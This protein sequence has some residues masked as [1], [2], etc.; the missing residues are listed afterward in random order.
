MTYDLK[1]VL[2]C[3]GRS[4]HDL[5]VLCG[6]SWPLSGPFL[7][8]LCHSWSLWWRSWPTLGTSVG[9]LGLLLGPAWAVVA[10]LGAFVGGLLPLLAHSWDLR[11]RSC[12]A[13]GAYVGGLG[14]SRGLCW[15]S[16][17]ALGAYVGGLGPL[18]GPLLAV[19]GR[20]GPKSGSGP[21]EKA[22][23]EAI[24]AEKWPKPEREGDQ[25]R[26]QGPLAFSARR[27]ILRIFSID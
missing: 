24:K 19:L 15:R 7:A 1:V 18:L 9:G 27:S 26:D 11:R 6:W 8:V 14:R 23:S 13:L 17:A 16:C 2:K 22:I 4:S 20:L 25:V 12:A 3:C 21:R 10:A 5:L